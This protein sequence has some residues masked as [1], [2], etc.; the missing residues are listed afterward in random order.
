M[1]IS[2]KKILLAENQS[3]NDEQA[4][5]YTQTHPGLLANI[6]VQCSIRVGTLQIS[7]AELK[8]L[9]S[10]E[11]LSLEQKTNDP[12]E[13]VLNDKVIARGEL[14]SIEDKFAMRITEV[15]S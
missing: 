8:Q 12:I 14:M 10:G 3:S 9:N 11:V 13:L 7:V 6:Q 15:N 1:S 4:I 2:V 5:N